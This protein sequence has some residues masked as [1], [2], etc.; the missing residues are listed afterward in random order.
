MKHLEPDAIEI[1]A[2]EALARAVA[3][4]ASP[5]DGGAAGGKGETASHLAECKEC[6]GHVR[7][8]QGRQK[9]LAG[10][11]PYTLSD[12]AFRRVEARLQEAVEAGEASPARWKWLWWAGGALAAATIALVVMTNDPTLPGVV[13]LPQPQVAAA[14][15]PFHPLTVLRAAAEA[16]TRRG[17]GEWRALA[18]GEV[19]L[20]GDALSADSV[21]LAPEGGAAWALTAT[22]SL[23][24][25]G[26]GSLT[27]GAGEVVARVGSPIEV[28]ASSRRMLASDAL[29]SVSRTGAEVV[30]LV[31]EGN[32]EVVDSVTGERRMVKAPQAVR[33]SDGSALK[34]GREEPIRA[35][36][37]PV[38]PG[39]PWTRFDTSSLL[40][41]TVVSLDGVS[42]GAA[43]FV[44]VVTAGRR[45][46]GLTPPGGV[47]QESWADLIGGQPFTAKLE[48]PSL[49]T[50]GPDPDAGALARVLAAIKAQRP[51]L[52]SCYDKWLKANPNAQGEVVLELTV[53]AQGRVKKARVEGSTISAASAECLVTTAKSLV[54]PPLGTD[55]TLQVPLVLRQPGR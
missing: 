53:G 11:T 32:V 52:A 29:F 46:L 38:I 24:L 2:R 6:R 42:L 36:P 25:G 21:A 50:E 13:K 27:L 20:S 23:S 48:A 31:A 26:A 44:E 40:A 18:V 41:G 47:L 45:R 51:K 19:A 35:L 30:L 12:M 10:M 17:E 28:L 4:Q 15:A 39:K 37:A 5:A 9:L 8:A 54:L 33:W 49:E 55:A 43:P 7:R 34:E 14:V 22:G 1:A 3:P 16:Q